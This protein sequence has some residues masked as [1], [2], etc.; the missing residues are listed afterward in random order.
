MRTFIASNK[1]GASRIVLNTTTKKFGSTV[2]EAYGDS[3]RINALAV[4]NSTMSEIKEKNVKG[5]H[6]FYVPGVVADAVQQG[7]F[8]YWLATGKNSKG[9]ELSKEELELWA[10]FAEHYQAMYLTAVVK[11]IKSA[12]LPERRRFKVTAEQ[13]QDNVLQGKAWANLPKVAETEEVEDDS[14]LFG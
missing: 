2:F 10:E 8:K 3:A 6:V 13:E 7:Y 4:L 14:V 11:N 5:L 1:G 9:E 12:S